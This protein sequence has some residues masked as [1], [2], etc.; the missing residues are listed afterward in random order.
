MHGNALVEVCPHCAAGAEKRAGKNLAYHSP[1]HCGHCGGWLGDAEAAPADQEAVARARLVGNWIAA[2][3]HIPDSAQLSVAPVLEAAAARYTKGR[4][5]VLAKALGF[6]K[7]TLHGWIKGT[8]VPSL[9]HACEL[10][11]RLGISLSDLYLGNKAALP[12]QPL[13]MLDG[14][15]QK[16][17]RTRIDWPAVDQQLQGYLRVVEP[18]SVRQIAAELGVSRRTLYSHDEVLMK[19]LAARYDAW[20][21]GNLEGIARERL[22]AIHGL[23]DA[24]EDE[25]LI[26]SGKVRKD[27][28]RLGH[29]VSWW[30]FDRLYREVSHGR[31]G[32]NPRKE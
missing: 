19:R 14:P 32:A 1:G 31:E 13:L 17:P 29:S 26:L 21:L 24:C 10:A 25:D 4:P 8:S 2:M 23:L 11:M 20:R 28:E 30:A 18:V 9:S 27:F 3:P 16:R 6:P 12:D 22:E 7:T 5:A 15:K